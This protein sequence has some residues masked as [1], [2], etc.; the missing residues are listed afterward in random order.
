MNNFLIVANGQFLPKEIIV[1]AAQDKTMIAL[2]GAAEKLRQMNI[3][4]TIILGDFDSLTKE[5]MQ[6]WEIKP[7]TSE[8]QPYVGKN[9]V[10]IIPALNQLYT[11]LEKA[12]Q[13]CDEQNTTNI[14]I[15]CATAGR[16]DHHEHV[17]HTLA[18]YYRRDRPILLHTEQQTLRYARDEQVII[19]GKPGDK[20]GIS[21]K[22]TGR[23]SSQGLKYECHDVETSFC[24]ELT[25]TSAILTITGGALL[26][27]PP[28]LISQ[29]IP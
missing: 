4:P 13:Y 17:M 11:D 7:I 9:N 25:G 24:N 29:Q 26:F 2:D 14:T 3:M 18:N 16:L 12:I 22:H 15:V 19:A 10:F 1:E 6:Y 23:V 28:Q 5:Q 21:A 20:C 27:L 8:Q